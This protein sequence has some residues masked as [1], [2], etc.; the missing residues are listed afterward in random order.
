MDEFE[1]IA[2]LRSLD[3]ELADHTQTLFNEST[4]YFLEKN[5]QRYFDQNICTP[6]Q[7]LI[8]ARKDAFSAIYR[9]ALFVTDNRKYLPKNTSY[10]VETKVM[11]SLLAVNKIEKI[12]PFEVFR[13]KRLEAVQKNWKN[14]N[15]KK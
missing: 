6:E 2:K 7:Q 10:E 5:K 8:Q 15:N 14:N 4:K 3:P 11:D 12:P 9:Y 13:R 1:L